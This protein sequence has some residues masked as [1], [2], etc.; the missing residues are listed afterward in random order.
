MNIYAH[1][2]LSATHPEN[3][4]AA[5]QAALDAGVYGVEL[6]IHL[7]ADG[8]PVVIHDDLLERTTNGIG[9]V[10]GKTVGDLREIDAGNG[11]YV[12]TFE[13]V[14]ALADGRLHFDIEIKGANCEQGVLDILLRHPGTRAAISA[15]EWAVLASVRSLNP[16]IELWVLTDTIS[17][18]ALDAAREL[19]ATTLAVEYLAISDSSMKKA[20]GAGF[21]V[22]AW[23]VNSQ[24][25]ADRLRSLGV[26][27]ICTDDP[28]R[29]R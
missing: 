24:K 9:S 13:E 23:T 21:D 22:M 1:R 8:V 12:P 10:T 20:I 2:G 17:S 18:R 25:E 5:F 3:T 16:S 26:V 4:L 19:G 15:F 29:I 6:D 14:V 7:S 28:T 27:A 11:Q